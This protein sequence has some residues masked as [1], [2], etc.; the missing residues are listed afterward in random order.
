MAELFFGGKIISSSKVKILATKI[1]LSLNDIKILKIIGDKNIFVINNFIIGDQFFPHRTF[2]NFGT[3]RKI[4][5][6]IFG[7]KKNINND[8]K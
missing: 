1:I 5:R 2:E 6:K 4:S 7:D 8:E 3:I